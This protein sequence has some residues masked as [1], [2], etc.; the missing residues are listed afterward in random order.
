M[1]RTPTSL[2]AVAAI[3]LAAC[4]PDGQPTATD[5]PSTDPTGAQFWNATDACCS[6]GQGGPD[7]SAYL[8]TI[9]EQ[10]SDEYNVDPKRI[11]FAG[12]SNGGFMSYRMACDH[13]DTIAAVASLAGAT[14]ADDAD[15]TPSEPV[16]VLQVHGTDDETIEYDG[17]SIQGDAFP[18][19]RDT[20]ETWAS[21]DECDTTPSVSAD[22]LDLDGGI[23][24]AESDVETYG[25]CDQGSEVALWTIDGGGHVP[26]VT[27]DFSAGVIDFLLAHPKS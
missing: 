21:H 23:E 17:G 22:E 4:S 10:V 25:G 14:F 3:G 27:S 2:F 9:I 5:A 8:L 11:F 1:R 24:G 20:V 7:D 26:G 19:A 15:C 18:S 13:A 6:G 12:H 16:S